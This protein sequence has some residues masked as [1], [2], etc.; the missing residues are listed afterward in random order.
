MIDER[1]NVPTQKKIYRKMRKLNDHVQS[2]DKDSL[3]YHPDH[4]YH[5]T[6][7][8]SVWVETFQHVQHATYHVLSMSLV[9]NCTLCQVSLFTYVHAILSQCVHLALQNLK[10]CS[11]NKF[12][13]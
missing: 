5:N 2:L 3:T 10:I 7:D 8:Y 13:K 9:Q 12:N 6:E 11:E 1:K 4:L